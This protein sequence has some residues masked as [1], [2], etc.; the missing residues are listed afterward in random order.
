M[1]PKPP[2]VPSQQKPC[3]GS[4]NSMRSRRVSAANR[5]AFA[6]PIVDALNAWLDAQLHLVSGRSMLAEAIRYA[7]S[8]WHDLTRFLNDGRVELHTNS[9]ERAIRPITLAR[10]NH[11]FARSDG[12]GH[13][14]AVI[15]SLITTCKLNDIEPYAYLRM[16]CSSWSTDIPSIASRNFCRGAGR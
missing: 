9:V 7:L 6:K 1:W 3:A 13:R 12:G 10:K 14:W 16:S 11:L 5:R 8:C 2:R 15:S 4:A